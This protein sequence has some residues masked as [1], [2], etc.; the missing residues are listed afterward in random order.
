MLIDSVIKINKP[1]NNPKIFSNI[2]YERD[3]IFYYQIGFI[4]I[5]VQEEQEIRRRDVYGN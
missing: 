2:S 4:K 1:W 5:E 3:E